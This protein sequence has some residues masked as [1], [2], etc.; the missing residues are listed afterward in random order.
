MCGLAVNPGKPR[1]PTHP[2]RVVFGR[3]TVRDTSDTR[4]LRGARGWDASATLPRVVPRF[5]SGVVW[6]MLL[7]GALVPKRHTCADFFVP[8][9]AWDNAKKSFWQVVGPEIAKNSETNEALF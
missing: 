4:D 3:A 7:S 9:G 5:W 6:C 1:P 2:A 8:E